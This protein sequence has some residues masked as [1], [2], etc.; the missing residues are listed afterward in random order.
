MLSL[1]AF[2]AKPPPIRALVSATGAPGAL[3]GAAELGRIAR[4]QPLLVDLAIPPDVDPAAAAGA[5]LRRIDMDDVTAEAARNSERRKEE[6]AAARALD[7]K[8]ADLHEALFVS[9]S[10]GPC[11][12]AL[13]KM[14][15]CLPDLRLPITPP[16]E[17]ACQVIDAAL[18]K[19]LA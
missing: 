19:A 5:G 2:R 7:A 1:D 18:A 6:S 15:L 17:A 10:P 4:E 14:G 11:K 8:L 9:P 12:Y 16:N 13:A 3:F